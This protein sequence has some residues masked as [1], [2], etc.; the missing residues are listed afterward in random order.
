[1][2]VKARSLVYAASASFTLLLAGFLVF[3]ASVARPVDAIPSTADGIVVL[4]GAERRIEAGLKLLR[5]GVG[6]RLL[7]SGIHARTTP[8]D[9]LRSVR[10]NSEPARC[11]VDFGYEARDTIG[12]ASETKAW[13]ERHRF[14]RLVVVTSSYHMPRSL[15]ELALALP[16][17]DLI[18]Y[19]VMP[20]ALGEGA[21]WLRPSAARVLVSEYL[22]LIP[23]Y[24]RYGAHQLF[25]PADTATALSPR[26]PL[27]AALR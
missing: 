22:K 14:T 18:A 20:R 1:M 9:V 24:V 3:A 6:N 19:P 16:G 5:D 2:E 12:N 4:T 11:C 7:I 10:G 8:D 17:V 15:N 23:S 25:R 21:W 13:A 27:S 26:P